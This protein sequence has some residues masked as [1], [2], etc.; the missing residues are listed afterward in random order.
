M[1]LVERG[2]AGTAHHEDVLD[3]I[4]AGDRRIRVLFDGHGRT[5][6]EL[7]VARDDYLRTG[8]LDAKAQ[9]LGRENTAEHQRVDGAEARHR[10][11]DDDGLGDHRQVDHEAVA[12]DD[13]ELG[14]RVGGL[15]RLAMQLREGELAAVAA[16]AL[17]EVGDALAEARIHVPVDAVD[18][19][20]ELAAR[21]PL[22]YRGR[23]VPSSARAGCQVC[24]VCRGSASR[25]GGRPPPRTR[26][27]RMRRAPCPPAARSGSRRPRPAAGSAGSR[28]RARRRACGMRSSVG[29]TW[30]GWCAQHEPSLRVLD[31]NRQQ[32]IKFLQTIELIWRTI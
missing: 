16:F 30:R 8:V 23:S 24:A 11:R 9:S 1:A 32:R 19:H 3:V 12:L 20:V 31:G 25:G 29:V 28:S 14:Q 10:E 6:P 13:A 22:R 7:A 21:E 18:G 5:P 26:Q 15:R 17:D 2:I 4:E 27:G